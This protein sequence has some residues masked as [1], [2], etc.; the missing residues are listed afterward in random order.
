MLTAE[1]LSNVYR[2]PVA[3]QPSSVVL[4]CGANV[5]LFSRFALE[6]GAGTLVAFEPSPTTAHCLRRNLAPEICTGRAVVIEQGLWDRD[7]TLS[8]LASNLSN[9]GA[10]HVT[11]GAVGDLQIT[12]TTIDHVVRDLALGA[13]SYIKM[14]IEGSEVR[15]LAGGRETISHALP[16]CAIATEHTEDLLGNARSVISTMRAID[17]G[18]Q[19]VC[20]EVHGYT[21]PSVGW[22]LTPY[23]LLFTHRGG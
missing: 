8:F 22:A 5:G 3:F 13:V 23:S 11:D 18:Y 6:R 17:V 9:P 2:L 16:T 12:A 19:Y 20:T 7:T 10:H 15:A 4:D 14:D 21:S 1:I